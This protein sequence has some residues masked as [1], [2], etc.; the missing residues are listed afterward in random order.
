MRISRIEIE[1]FREFPTSTWPWATTRCSPAR[2]R[3]RKS[4]LLAAL[5]LVLDPSLPDNRP[6][7]QVRGFL[8][9]AATAR[10]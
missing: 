9:R 4:N 3:S 10:T 2:T 6:R 5:R 8:G 1:N 7:A